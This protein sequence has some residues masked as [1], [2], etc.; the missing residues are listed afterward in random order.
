MTLYDSG[1]V[2]TDRVSRRRRKRNVFGE[3]VACLGVVGLFIGALYAAYFRPDIV[4]TIACMAIVS[5]VLLTREEGV[6]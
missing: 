2:T 3:F 6:K 4:L 5:A 1:S